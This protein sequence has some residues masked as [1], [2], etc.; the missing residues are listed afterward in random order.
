MAASRMPRWA[1]PSSADCCWP[2]WPRC[3]LFPP[4]SLSSTAGWKA[5]ARRRMA[6]HRSGLLT[7]LT[8]FRS[9]FSMTNESKPNPHPSIQPAHGHG[10]APQQKPIS[11]RKALLGVALMVVIAGALAG[12]GIL[13][14][15]RADKALAVRT[16]ELAAPTVIAANPRLGAPVDNF[17]LPGNVTAYTDSPIYARTSGYLTRWYFD[18][19]A[20]V[21]KG[22]LL[23]ELATPELDQQLSQAKADLATA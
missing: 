14:R 13:L 3:F 17:V 9:N 11:P 8:S 10:A 21:K 22:A 5:A 23:A 12:V 18:I 20:R 2:P 7:S 4:F 6:L 1:A 15:P 16:T 19:G